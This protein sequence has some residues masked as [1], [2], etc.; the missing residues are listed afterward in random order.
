MGEVAFSM[1]DADWAALAKVMAGLN[2]TERNIIRTQAGLMYSGYMNP[3]TQ[4][5]IK[6]AKFWRNMMEGCSFEIE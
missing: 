4:S 6:H 3:M 1:S 2:E 5:E